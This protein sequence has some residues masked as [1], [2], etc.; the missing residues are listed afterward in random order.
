M[1]MLDEEAEAD[2]EDE[3][4]DQAVGLLVLMHIGTEELRRLRAE[5]R[6]AHRTYLTRPDLLPNPQLNTPWQTLYHRRNDRA[7]ITTMGIDVASFELILNAGFANCWS[8][9]A[10]TRN[11]VSLQA[12]PRVY[13]RSLDAAGC[14]GLVLHFLNSTMSEVS[15]QQIFALIPST[16]SRYI[17]FSLPILLEVLKQMPQASIQWPEGDQFQEL[18]DLVVARHPLLSGAFGTMDGLNLPVQVSS[19]QDIENSCYNG[20]LHA[21]FISSVLAFSA[22]GKLQYAFRC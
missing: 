13:T 1:S 22:N 9:T 15:L 14:L 12:A 17:T 5:R 19:D 7:F 2:M 11:D 18:N 16:V 21:H 20:W 6:L 10:I 8:N 4:L 3:L